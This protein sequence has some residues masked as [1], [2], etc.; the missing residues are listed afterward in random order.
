MCHVSPVTCHVSHV[1]CHVSY[2]MRQRAPFP[3]SCQ[4]V[5]GGVKDVGVVL[6]L[7]QLGPLELLGQLEGLYI[8]WL[9]LGQLSLG[10]GI[11]KELY[12]MLDK[13]TNRLDMLCP[14]YKT[15]CPICCTICPNPDKIELVSIQMYLL[16]LK[17]FRP[18]MFGPDYLGLAGPIFWS[19]GCQS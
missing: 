6:D 19:P 15:Y 1:M 16:K 14:I 18:N 5:V 9:G 13:I 8:V 4:E 17:N 3:W 7:V 10:L 11:V 12:V 2:A